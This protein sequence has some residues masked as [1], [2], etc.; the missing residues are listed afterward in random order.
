MKTILKPQP[1]D[2]APYASV[3]MDLVPDDGHVLDLMQAN[4]LE[5]ERIA[6]AQTPEYLVTPHAPGEWTIQEILLHVMDTERIVAYRALRIAR[7]D[8]TPLPGFEQ[9][10]YVPRSGANDRALEDL[11]AEYRAVR[12]ATLTLFDGLPDEAFNR[13]GTAS[14]HRLTVNAAACFIAGHELHHIRSIQEN[15]L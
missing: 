3:Y 2:Y 10:A 4:L 1:G 11:L 15:Y 14:N 5:V 6:R 12:Q 13:A 7:G 8:T 9:D